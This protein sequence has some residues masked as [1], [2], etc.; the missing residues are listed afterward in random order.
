MR[1]VVPKFRSRGFN[2]VTTIAK[3]YIDKY[4]DTYILPNLGNT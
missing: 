4:I 1:N 3:T 2:G